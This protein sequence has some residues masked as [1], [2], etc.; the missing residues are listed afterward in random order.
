LSGGVNGGMGGGTDGGITEGINSHADYIKNT[1]GRN[2]T[3]IT[4]DLDIPERSVEQWLKKLREQ[5]EI[6]FIGPRKTGG[7]HVT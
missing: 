5:G 4:V 2:V 3:K 7:Y 6:V 1:P